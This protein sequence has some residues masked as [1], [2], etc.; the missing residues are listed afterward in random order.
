MPNYER[1]KILCFFPCQ[2]ATK[3]FYAPGFSQAEKLS[4]VSLVNVLV[5]VPLALLWAL[6]P[7]DGI[8]L[9]ADWFFK[10]VVDVVFELPFSRG[11]ETEAD[12]VGLV[13]AAKACLDVTEAPR[14]WAHL[15]DVEREEQVCDEIFQKKRRAPIIYVSLFAGRHA[16]VRL[17]PPLPRD[18]SRPPH[19]PPPFGA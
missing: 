15:A 5:L 19:R 13:L 16:R 6:L 2:L 14:F 9:V 3:P 1:E 10:R 17:Y 4:Y 7:T 8:A 11:M 18:P 12:E